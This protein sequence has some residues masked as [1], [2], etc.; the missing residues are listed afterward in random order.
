MG[1][2]TVL[3]Q[4]GGRSDGF[5]VSMGK[6]L[7]SRLGG[8]L[9]LVGTDC[10]LEQVSKFIEMS[11][12]VVFACPVVSS[13]I[14][15]P[16]WTIIDSLHKSDKAAVLVVAAGKSRFFCN[17]SINNAMKAIRALGFSPVTSIIVDN[18]YQL[19]KGEFSPKHLR[20]LEKASKLIL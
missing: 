2:D 14:F 6:L 10:E 15:Y 13:E 1:K 9:I 16:F 12:V 4:C 17:K 7:S 20:R 5:S 11:D 8:K 19:V 3:I 18:T